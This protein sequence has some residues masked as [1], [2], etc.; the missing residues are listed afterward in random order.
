MRKGEQTRK[1]IV[2]K[3]YLLAG[4]LGLEGV[5]L[6]TLATS[7]SLS[8]SGLFAHFK[9]KEA[10]QLE[11]LE[12]AIGRFTRHVVTPALGKPRGLPRLNAMFDGYLSWI[13]GVSGRG[14]CLFLSLAHEY[15]DR[16]GPVRDRLVESQRA[17]LDTLARAVKLAVSEGHLRAQVDADQAAIE[18]VGIGMAYQHATRLLKDPKADK[19]ARAAYDALLQ[20]LRK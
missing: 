11:V 1:G 19:R 10:L 9:S 15:D 14:S 8:K 12:E 17:W 3:A 13:R 4:Q 5:T 16:P 18:L 20:R 7:L 6:G 2:D